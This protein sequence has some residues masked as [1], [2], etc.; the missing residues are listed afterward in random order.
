MGGAYVFQVGERI[1]L[2]GVDYERYQMYSYCC[3]CIA[4]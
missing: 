4:A 1:S 2:K 3:F